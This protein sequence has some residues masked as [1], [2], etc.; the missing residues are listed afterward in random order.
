MLPAYNHILHFSNGSSEANS[1]EEKKEV[2][3][4]IH[5]DKEE[6]AT[7]IDFSKAEVNDKVDPNASPECDNSAWTSDSLKR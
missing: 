1:I 2:E 3:E 7:N 4:T 6:A 5:E